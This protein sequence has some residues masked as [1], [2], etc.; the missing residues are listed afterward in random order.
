MRLHTVELCFEFAV[1]DI[2]DETLIGMDFLVYNDLGEA[3][4]NLKTNTSELGQE[5]RPVIKIRSPRQVR[6]VML[7]ESYD[8]PPLCEKIIHVYV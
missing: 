2:Q 7:A 3:E 8:I 4:L 5:L 6:K 1:A